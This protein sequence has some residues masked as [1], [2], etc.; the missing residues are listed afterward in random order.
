MPKTALVTGAAGFIGRHLVRALMRHGWNV[1]GLDLSAQPNTLKCRW[2]RASILN[3]D[4]VSSAT[5]QCDT[6]FHLAAHAH[7]S[8][9][10]PRI[11][12]DVNV[13]GTAAILSAAQR[14]GVTH[15]IATSSAVIWQAPFSEGTVTEETPLPERHEM[16]G[17][18]ARSKW[19]ANALLA[20]AAGSSMR[21][22]R[23]YPTVPI[24]PGDVGMTAP[25]QM[26][27]LFMTKPPPA[28]LDTVFDFVPVEDIAQAHMNAAVLNTGAQK[29]FIL[30]GERWTMQ[31]L[32]AFLKETSGKRMPTRTIPYAAART[33]AG[34]F[35]PFQ[36]L[37][38]KHAITSVEGIRLSSAR[39]SF[40]NQ[41]ARQALQWQPGAV[42]NALKTTLHWLGTGPHQP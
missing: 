33:A 7:L 9:P 21:I 30:S 41:A 26:L 1:T 13:K 19:D 25:T 39:R 31:T 12:D 23:L 17:P 28:V 37:R 16:A 18:Y 3:E 36:H 40:S 20:K 29:Q 34:I 14:A 32:L 27:N 24:G 2:V 8:A 22:T 4:A 38:G 10:K 6:V 42:D 35:E 15:F 5:T 11:Y